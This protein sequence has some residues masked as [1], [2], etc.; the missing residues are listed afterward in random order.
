MAILDLHEPRTDPKKPALSADLKAR[1]TRALDG[2]KA[3]ASFFA[4]QR[5]REVEDLKFVEID[6]Q[7]DPSVKTQR[8]GNQSVNGLPPTPPRPMVTINQL[9]GPCQQ[10][11]NARR[12]ARLGLEFAPKGAGASDDIAEV[13]EDIARA[14]QQESRASIA[15][16]WAG[17]RAEKAGMG[18]YEIVTDYC[19]DQSDPAAWNDQD[20]LWRRILNQGSVYPD[21]YAQQ[22]DFSDGRRWYKTEDLPI[23]LYRDR[24]PDSELATADDGELTAIGDAQPK[25]VFTS[26]D[27]DGDEAQT[28]R[29]AECWEVVEKVRTIVKLTDGRGAFDDE[30]PDGATVDTG[31]E[32]ISRKKRVRTIY[33]SILNAVEY[34]EEPSEYDGDY[35]PLIP[36]VGEES[37]VDG[38]RR[39]Q[40]IV[41]PGRDSAVSYNVTRSAIQE[42]IA[43]VSKAPYIGFVRTIGQFM[44]WWKQ[45]A[46]RNFPILPVEEAYDKQGNLLPIPQ[47]NPATADISALTVAAQMAKDDVHTTTGVPPVALGQLDPHDRSG[48]AIAALQGQSEIGSSGYLENFKDISLGLEGKI[49]RDLIPRIFDRP[50]RIVPAVGV[51][52]KRR[53]VMLNAPYIEGPDGHPHMLPNWREGMPVPTQIPGPNGQPIE[54]KYYNLKDGQY[55]VTPV[56]G[57]SYATR[58]QEAGA[59]IGD[60]MK[61]VPPEMAMAIA[62]AWLDE[63]DYPG[64][65]KIAEIAKNALP[66]GLRAAYQDRAEG[67]PD[68]QIEQLQQQVQQLQ[69][70]IQSKAAEKQAE[71]QAKGQ[72]EFQKEQLDSQTRIKIALIQASASMTN[73]QAKIDAEDARTFIDAMENRLSTAL[74]MHMARLGQAHEAIQAVHDQV[75]EAALQASDQQHEVGMAQLGHDQALEQGQQAAA[76]APQPE[77][78]TGA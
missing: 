32:A 23:A 66:P 35:V 62:P 75:H 2:F 9:R 25:W 74:E 36:C 10:I 77:A 1:H 3:S 58:R 64:A 11:A 44:E 21:P 37:N 57:K 63:Q 54:V 67:G 24:Y 16:N 27:G 6:E 28:V 22:P 41:R 65:K 70:A 19:E 42:A 71:V 72:I 39:W 53:L 18:W 60:V 14:V 29:I 48:K 7:W 30:I 78:G 33:H 59:A 69:Q 50:G 8:A 15:R 40:G 4:Q 34:L 43:L 26:T 20:I 52:E 13:F 56:V 76:L 31:P 55:S 12:A 73:S 47:R 38:E 5:K 49:I 46:V 51:D 17:D 45:S 61:A 68:P